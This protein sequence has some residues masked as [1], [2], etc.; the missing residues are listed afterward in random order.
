MLRHDEWY[1]S[2]YYVEPTALYFILTETSPH[3]QSLIACSLHLLLWKSHSLFLTDKLWW[4]KYLSICSLNF[5]LARWFSC[6]HLHSTFMVYC[7]Y[8][9]WLCNWIIN[10][11]SQKPKMG[12]KVGLVTI[13]LLQCVKYKHICIAHFVLVSYNFEHIFICRIW[14]EWLKLWICIG[15]IFSSRTGFEAW[16]FTFDCT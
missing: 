11:S 10:N 4:I 3:P 13:V 7:E 1:E 9:E 6:F 5:F 12:T 16:A 15:S 2:D 14:T 8:L